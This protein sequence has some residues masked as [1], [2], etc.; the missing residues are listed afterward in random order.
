MKIYFDTEFT[1]L[2]KNSDLISIGCVT[3]NGHQF[4]AEFMDYNPLL[5]DDWLQKNV[6]DNLL[7]ND[8]DKFIKRDG[9]SIFMKD[10]K[11]NIKDTFEIFI[12]DMKYVIMV[13]DISSYDW[14]LFCDMW[15]GALN[16]PKKIDPFC[17]DIGHY[18]EDKGYNPFKHSREGILKKKGIVIDGDKHNSLY[19][20]K[21]IKEIANLFGE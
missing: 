3:E 2:V 13:S 17:R 20:A 21:V 10:I 19:D 5:V 12:S 4:Y 16:I 11:R 18:L 14:V 1:G 7:F 9:N 6:I 8:R 15:E